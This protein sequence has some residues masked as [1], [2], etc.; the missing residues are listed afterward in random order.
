VISADGTPQILF[1]EQETGS[2]LYQVTPDGVI[3]LRPTWQESEAAVAQALGP[4]YSQQDSYLNGL[5]VGYGT[6]GSIRVDNSAPI[7][8]GTLGISGNSAPV[9]AVE[10]KNY[11]VGNNTQSLINDASQSIIDQ[12]AQLPPGSTQQ[13]VIDTTGQLVTPAQEQAIT[14]SIVQKS[15]GLIQASDIKFFQK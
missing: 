12:A 14:Q 3:S 1:T 11:N 2:V 6:P 4:Q 7:G 5:E 15:N 13:L 10:V 8:E 9:N